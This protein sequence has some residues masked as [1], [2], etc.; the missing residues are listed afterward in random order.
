MLQF[1]F[2]R[3][4]IV[5]FGVLFSTYTDVRTGLIYDKVTY[6]MILLGAFLLVFEFTSLNFNYLYVVVPLVVFVI[7]YIMYFMG[8]IGG[9]D[10]KLFSA[11]ALLLPVVEGEIF[12]LNVLFIAAITSIVFLSV[13]YFSKY[14]RKGIRFKENSRDIFKALVFGVIL[15]VYFS[16]LVNLG[17]LSQGAIIFLLLP[18]LFGLLFMAFQT[19]IKRNFFLKKVPLAK[20]EEDEIVAKEFLSKPALLALNAGFKGVLSPKEIARLKKAGVGEVPVYRGLPPFAPFILLGVI[21][22]QFFP[23]FFSE[24]F[25]L[26]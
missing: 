9:G 4:V 23:H 10:V 25:F 1:L 21:F 12:L 24:I 18:I 14:A 8:K 17:Y 20:L 2:W 13:Y 7:G 22:A 5:L 6:P 26:L 3:E 19:G 16:T 11:I 15:T